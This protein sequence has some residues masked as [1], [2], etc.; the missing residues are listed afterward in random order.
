MLFNS[1]NSACLS[2]ALLALASVISPFAFSVA[3]IRF[4]PRTPLRTS[5]ILF[6]LLPIPLLAFTIVD[7]ASSTLPS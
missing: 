2:L 6:I 5:T 4:I 3:L 7:N 1:L